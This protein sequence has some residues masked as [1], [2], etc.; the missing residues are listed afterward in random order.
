MD[1][2]VESLTEEW[3]NLVRL[4]PRLLVA[5]IIFAISIF[6]G[7]LIGKAVVHILAR[8][9]FRP[10][11]R[12]FFRNLT[13]WLVAILGLILALNVLGLKGLAASLMAGGGITA[14]IL[15]FAFREIGENFLAGFFLAFSR[16]FEIGDLV[17]SGDLQGIVKSIE[18]RS[19][20]IRT[21]DG[22]DIYIPSSEIFNKPV[23]NFTKDGLRLLSFKV[24]IDYAD[25][26]KKAQQLLIETTKG[27]SHVLEDP[28]PDAIFSSLLA[29]YVEL[30]VFFWIDTFE[31]GVNLVAVRN[32]VIERCRRSLMAGDFTVSANVTS[33]IAL[34]GFQPVDVRLAQITG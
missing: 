18:L 14:I 26:S 24:G 12:N 29:Q 13:A 21:A 2:L 33:N 8:G 4:T 15:G 7:R 23:T 22:R 5:L 6:V 3:Q 34:G 28:K 1:I 17:Q 25:D 31:E 16:P 19:T 32:E 20:H 11:H 30:E 10:T 27:V 9:N